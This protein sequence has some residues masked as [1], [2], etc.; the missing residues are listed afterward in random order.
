MRALRRMVGVRL[1]PSCFI[2]STP[3]MHVTS[4]GHVRSS[5]ASSTMERV[6][7]VFGVGNPATIMFISIQLYFLQYIAH[8][9]FPPGLRDLRFEYRHCRDVDDVGYVVPWHQQ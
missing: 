9:P 2:M 4:A 3:S 5:I 7:R 1:T 6:R 8:S